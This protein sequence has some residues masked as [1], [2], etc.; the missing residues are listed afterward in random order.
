MILKKIYKI[1]LDNELGSGVFG[2]LVKAEAKIGL[3]N[4]KPTLTV[5]VKMVRS[6]SNVIAAE[7]LVNE[8]KLL[9]HLGLHLNIVNLLGS[10]TEGIYAGF[11]E[12]SSLAKHFIFLKNPFNCFTFSGN[13]FLIIDYCRHGNLK[14]Y[15]T[16]HRGSYVNQMNTFRGIFGKLNSECSST[17]SQ[18]EYALNVYPNIFLY[19]KSNLHQCRIEEIQ[20]RHEEPIHSSPNVIVNPFEESYY[21]DLE[22]YYNIGVHAPADKDIIDTSDCNKQPDW[23]I[24]YKADSKASSSSSNY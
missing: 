16:N 23:S 13:L 22:Y 10:C 18:A 9:I 17:S 15:L 20:Q 6:K 3:I 1:D 2:R 8:L 24:N 12:L 5:A 4:E 14:D 11:I 7:Y 19:L 21:K